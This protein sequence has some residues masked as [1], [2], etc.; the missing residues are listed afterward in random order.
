MAMS[1]DEEVA[2]K[3]VILKKYVISG[4]P[5]KPDVENLYLSCDSVWRGRM[6]K[7]EGS[8]IDSYM[9]GLPLSGNAWGGWSSGFR[10][11]RLQEK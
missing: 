10:S 4:L 11:S 6:R 3:Q 5:K 8:Y 7:R 9:P 2:N 1:G